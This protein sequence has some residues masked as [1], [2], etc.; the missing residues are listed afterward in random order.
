MNHPAILASTIAAIAMLT[1]V[2]A[3]GQKGPDLGDHDWIRDDPKYLMPGGVHCCDRSHC[4]PLPDSEVQET[5][6][7]WIYLPT[8][9]VFKEGDPGVYPSKEWRYF[10]CG[11]VRPWCFF[12][13]PG[14]V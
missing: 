11:T 1:A 14:G 6:D 12:F 13:K 3:F 7:G 4:H 9:Q 10:A 5:K 8:G 2:A